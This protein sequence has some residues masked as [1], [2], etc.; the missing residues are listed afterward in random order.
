MSTNAIALSRML[1]A[2]RPFLVRWIARIVGEPAAE[3]VAQNLYMRVQRVEDSPPIL[4]MRAYLLRL[5]ANEAWDKG[6][7]LA[8]QRRLQE[9]ANAILWGADTPP[10]IDRVLI[11]REALD[12]VLEAADQLSE[13]TRTIFWL[14]R[15]QGMAQRDIA[16]QLGVSRTTVE[17]HIR[18][19]MKLLS[20]ARDV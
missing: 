4:N 12:R 1:T 9:Q 11:A 16:V 7:E 3:D 20:E 19:A 8:R 13:P 15:I 14:N 6:R 10:T 5:A 2:E 18:R 17:K